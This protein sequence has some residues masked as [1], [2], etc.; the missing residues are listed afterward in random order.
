[1]KQ[2]IAQGAQ[3]LQNTQIQLPPSIC[4]SLGIPP[5]AM[6]PFPP[7]GLAQVWTS[8]PPPT[9]PPNAVNAQIEA[10]NIQQNSL[11]DQIRQ[12]EQNLQAQHGVNI[13]FC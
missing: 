7:S 5:S 9:A 3:V 2:Q 1:M 10:L 8:T 12:S 4:A 6:S 11:R 13:V